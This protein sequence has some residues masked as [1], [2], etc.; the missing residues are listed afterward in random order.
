VIARLLIAGGIGK[1]R[2]LIM[3]LGEVDPAG[4]ARRAEHQRVDVRVFVPPT[5][6][7]SL[8][9]ESVPGPVIQDLGGGK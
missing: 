1:E 6:K 2:I 4:P 9:H 5:V 3:G 8:L 7:T